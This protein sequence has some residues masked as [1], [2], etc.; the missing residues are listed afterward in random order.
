MIKLS[1]TASEE[2]KRLIQSQSQ[3]GAEATFL[4]VAVAA[5]GC[6]GWSYRLAFDSKQENEDLVTEQDGVKVVC[7]PQSHRMLNGAEI[8]FEGGL[9]GRGF[10]FHN[11]N[12]AN[13]CGCGDSFC[14]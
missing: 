5:G 13:T 14:S 4:R 3:G 7:D 1:S 12:A 8:H 11:P 2:I 9:Q 10:V 6:S